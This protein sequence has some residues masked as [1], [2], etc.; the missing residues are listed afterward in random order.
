[1]PLFSIIDLTYT[2]EYAEF[3]VSTIDILIY[4]I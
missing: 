4:S 3:E 1:M 2:R